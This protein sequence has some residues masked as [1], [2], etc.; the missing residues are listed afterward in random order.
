MKKRYNRK[1][2]KALLMIII[3]N[4]EIQRYAPPGFYGWKEKTKIH[5]LRKRWPKASSCCNGVPWDYGGHDVRIPR[6]VF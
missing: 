1:P 5:Y 2:I 3:G 4:R 6:G